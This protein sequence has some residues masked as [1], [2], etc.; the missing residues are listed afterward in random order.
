M[1]EDRVK[2]QVMLCGELRRFAPS[3]VRLTLERGHSLFELRI[4]LALALM[5]REQNQDVVSL[6]NLTHFA[7]DNGRLADDATLEADTRLFT[8]WADGGLMPHHNHCP[9][10][11]AIPG[12][13]RPVC[14]RELRKFKE[15]GKR[16]KG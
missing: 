14:I 10:A 4:A 3:P 7:D 11:V 16:K 15:E 6:I 8:C 9:A 13:P 2:V 12:E 5:G 1:D